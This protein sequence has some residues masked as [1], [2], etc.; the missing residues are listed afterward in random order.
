MKGK[1]YYVVTYDIADDRRRTRVYDTLR[2]WGNPLQYSVFEVEVSARQLALLE[3]ELAGHVNHA[4]DQVL[5]FDLGP[6]GE[7]VE[8]RVRHLGRPWSYASARARVF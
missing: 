2:C 3:T 4:H 6:L 1:R 7:R 8:S 5:F